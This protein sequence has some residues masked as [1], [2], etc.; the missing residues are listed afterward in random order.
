MYES[1]HSCT[2]VKSSASKIL[3]PKTSETE[4]VI[5]SSRQYIFPA[6]RIPQ[7]DKKK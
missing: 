1:K 4:L 5:F 6:E 7:C 2:L 3:Y